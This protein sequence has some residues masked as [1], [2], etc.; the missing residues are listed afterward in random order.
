M[1]KSTIERLYIRKREKEKERNE[2]GMK[3]TSNEKMNG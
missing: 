1:D 3:C 2:K